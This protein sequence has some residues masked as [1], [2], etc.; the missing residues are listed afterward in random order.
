RDGAADPGA[1]P[2]GDVDGAEDLLVLEHVAGERGALVG[3]DP[4]L[5]EVGSGLAGAA[6]QRE[7]ALAADAGRLGEPAVAHREH[8][9]PLADRSERRGRQPALAGQRRYEA[10][11][12]GEVPEGPAP[13][14]VA[15][16]GDP[17]AAAQ[18]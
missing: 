9:L 2:E 14:E 5:G 6:Q 3:A 13:G 12:A 10:L 7:Q 16:V 4:Q 15:V 1:R 11:A 17:L 8:R 18:I